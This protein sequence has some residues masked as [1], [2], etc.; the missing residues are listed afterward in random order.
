MNLILFYRVSILTPHTHTLSLITTDIKIRVSREV[1]CHLY[2]GLRHASTD[3]LKRVQI[4][5]NQCLCGTLTGGNKSDY[6]RP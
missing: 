1:T 4:K 6:A 5:S 3:D 2:A